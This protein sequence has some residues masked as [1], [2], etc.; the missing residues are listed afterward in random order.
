MCFFLFFFTLIE[1][2][3]NHLFDVFLK[4]LWLKIDLKIKMSVES[5]KAES[6]FIS[7]H[8]S[9]RLFSLA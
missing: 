2:P 6:I 7:F 3:Y 8:E 4:F 9:V 1:E 5:V